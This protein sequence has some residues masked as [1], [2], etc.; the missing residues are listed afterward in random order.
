MS[1]GPIVTANDSWHRIFT[2]PFAGSD[3]KIDV[4]Y[5]LFELVES[6]HAALEERVT[7]NCRL[8][9]ISASIEKADAESGFQVGNDL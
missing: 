1:C 5:A 8:D 2:S 6:G 9:A 3:R 7:I 4:P